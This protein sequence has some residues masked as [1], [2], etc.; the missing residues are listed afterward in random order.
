MNKYHY[1][2][3]Y[4]YLILLFMFLFYLLM[5]HILFFLHVHV[6]EDIYKIIQVME[7][8]LIV[9]QIIL[10]TFLNEY[11]CP[12]HINLL[13]NYHYYHLISS[14]LKIMVNFHY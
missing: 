13:H 3:S 1:V 11:N 6:Q 14:N 8:N 5:I 12:I 10:I 4:D 9:I 7:I 2:N